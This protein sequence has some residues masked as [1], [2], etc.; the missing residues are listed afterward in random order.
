VIQQTSLGLFSIAISAKPSRVGAFVLAIAVFSIVT[1]V[2]AAPSAS[3]STAPAASPVIYKLVDASGR[4]TYTNSP[5]KGAIKVELDPITVIPSSPAGMLGGGQAGAQANVSPN[6]QSAAA[7]QLIP[8][9]IAPTIAKPEAPT[10]PVMPVAS[11]SIQATQP[12]FAASAR[13]SNVQ[14]ATAVVTPV[15]AVTASRI[16][17]PPARNAE[18]TAERIVEAPATPAYKLPVV[19]LVPRDAA[20][21]D[22]GIRPV[23]DTPLLPAVASPAVVSVATVLPPSPVT[24]AI[25]SA[26]EIELPVPVRPSLQ[27]TLPAPKFEKEEQLLA[28]LKAQLAEQQNASASFRAMRARL[29]TTIDQSDPTKAAT[30]NDIKAQVEQHFERIR[31]LQDQ[32]TQREQ[33]LAV[34]RQ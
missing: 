11:S 6:A 30:Q 31:S 4:I 22:I 20:P 2:L 12:T 21:G 17:S 3:Q 29:P 25:A 7:P 9:G 26:R 5:T 19:K 10:M 23:A 34:L 14:P 8:V 33:N 13:V 24:V 18:Q 15:S 32:I 1:N 28:S 27:S 16:Q